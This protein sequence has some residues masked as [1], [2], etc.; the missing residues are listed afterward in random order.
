[1]ARQCFGLNFFGQLGLGDNVSRG[2]LDDD[3]GDF[4]P[5]VDLGTDLSVVEM[6]VGDAHNCAILSDMSLKCWGKN[7]NGRLGLGDK[8]SRGLEEFDMGDNL[9]AVDLGTNMTASMVAAGTAHTCALLETGEVKC[10][11]KSANGWGQLGQ[12]DQWARGNRE[13]T[14]GDDLEVVNLGAGVLATAVAVG[15]QHSCALLQHGGVKCWGQNSVGQL[16]TGNTTNV[17]SAVG[18]MGDNLAEIDLGF[19]RYAMKISCGLFHTC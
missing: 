4:L 11:G 13:G 16:G 7:G 17:G 9:P 5:Q 1:M 10:W 2:H 6:T 19:G 14:M 18:D 12:E 3:M 15:S 8:V